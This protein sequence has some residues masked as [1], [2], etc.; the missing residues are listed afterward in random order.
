MYVQMSKDGDGVVGNPA[1][2]VLSGVSG[3][4]GTALRGKLAVRGA[5]VVQLVR[6]APRTELA[7]AVPGLMTE[8]KVIKQG[9]A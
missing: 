8:G 3:M 9:E 7:A 5:S 4:L 2:I 1:K 6:S